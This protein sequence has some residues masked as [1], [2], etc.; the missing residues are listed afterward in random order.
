MLEKILRHLHN[1]FVVPGGI[2][3]GIFAI[4]GGNITLPFLIE[5]QYYRIVGSVL[6]D[7]LHQYSNMETLTD[8]TFDG[9]IWALAIPREMIA[10]AEE[11]KAWDEKYAEIVNSPYTSESFGGYSYTKAGKTSTGG[12]QGASWQSV[13]R[14][15]LNPYR[16]I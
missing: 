16:K 1:W 14:E 11:I 7:G 4:K 3:Y 6:N 5:G 10:L 15:R 12:S 9:A 2:H 8:E 13:F